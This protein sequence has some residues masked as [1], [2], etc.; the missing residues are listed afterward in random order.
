[1][2][3]GTQ[4]VRH[5]FGGGWATDYGP[6]AEVTI[7]NSGRVVIPFLVDAE[8]VEFEFDG[9]PHKIG[10]AALL[11]TAQINAGATI[12]GLF[13]F[14]SINSGNPFQRPACCS[15]SLSSPGVSRL[16]MRRLPPTGA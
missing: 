10:G 13:D 9:G 4:N 8:N 3:A 16:R 14:W 2:P 11:N 1:M 15:L 5:T 6:N 7:D 12:R